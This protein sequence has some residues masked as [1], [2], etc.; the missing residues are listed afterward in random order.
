MFVILF[1]Y[2]MCTIKARFCIVVCI[3]TNQQ[4]AALLTCNYLKL[5]R[6]NIHDSDNYIPGSNMHAYRARLLDGTAKLI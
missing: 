3:I 1:F 6:D 4:T 2:G 5:F